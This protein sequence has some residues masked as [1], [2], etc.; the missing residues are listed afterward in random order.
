M[1]KRPSS[2]AG[3][4]ATPPAP[5]VALLEPRLK[6]LRERLAH[7]RLDAILLTHAAD[8]AYLTNFG[9]HDS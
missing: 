7:L 8:I 6:A 1:A 9:G 4:S 2:P 5:H 3:T